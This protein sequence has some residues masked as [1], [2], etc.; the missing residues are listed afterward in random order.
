MHGSLARHQF[1]NFFQARLEAAQDTCF[2]CVGTVGGTQGIEAGKVD[3][4]AVRLT[5]QVGD[6]PGHERRIDHGQP[7]AFLGHQV[8]PLVIEPWI[9]THLVRN[10]DIDAV[11]MSIPF[12]GQLDQPEQR[13]AA[14]ARHQ[15]HIG[16]GPLP[17]QRKG[18]RHA[19]RDNRK[20]NRR[21]EP[22]P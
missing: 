9:G 1:H 15:L 12:A 2:P 19:D 11:V 17:F 16:V 20:Q 6:L 5:R 3:L 22:R 14:L 18:Q 21:P 10:R 13:G 4:D 8:A 7:D